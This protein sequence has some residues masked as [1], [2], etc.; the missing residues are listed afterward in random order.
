MIAVAEPTDELSRIYFTIRDQDGQLVADATGYIAGQLKL[1]SNGVVANAVGALV[2]VAPLAVPPNGE[3][4][5]Q[6]DATER[7]VGGFRWARLD[8]RDMSGVGNFGEGWDAIGPTWSAGETDP[9]L[10]RHP[11][12]I[13]DADN[14]LVAGVATD[15][16]LDVQTSLDG[17][18][19][20]AAVGT[21]V[22]TT[23][24]GLYYYQGDPTEAAAPA[25]L[26]VVIVSDISKPADAL[27]EIEAPMSDTDST[28]PETAV[29]SPPV[30]DVAGVYED[31]KDTEL[32]LDVTD[33]VALAY[34][35]VFARFDGGPRISVFRRGAFEQGFSLHSF[36]EDLAPD[37]GVAKRLHVRRDVG[38][39]PGEVALDTDPVDTGGNVGT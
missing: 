14:A 33:D 31:V 21:L 32:V 27:I 12:T 36:V 24:V 8:T 13:Y 23:L 38:W 25:D 4:Y 22:E 3:H 7:A 16:G 30:G 17:A 6:L 11:I 29:V 39:P 37:D 18:A 1:C 19:L 35:A 2:A 9:T 28:A 15:G 20:I 10:L 5:L 26:S 34:I